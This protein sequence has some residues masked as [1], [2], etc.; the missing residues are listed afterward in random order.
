MY[1][2]CRRFLSMAQLEIHKEKCGG[3][4]EVLGAGLTQD[5]LVFNCNICSAQF[6]DYQ[7]AQEHLGG[8]KELASGCG[9]VGFC[10]LGFLIHTY[11][12][13]W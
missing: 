1:L 6:A 2:A 8:H 4:G 5:D 7:R 12:C 9:Q 10:I 11:S 13:R 3:L